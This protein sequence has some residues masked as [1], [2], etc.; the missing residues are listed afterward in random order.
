MVSTTKGFTYKIPI[1]PTTSTP[2]KKPSVGK[3]LCL[4]Y[5][6]L[7]AQKKNVPVELELLN[8]SARKLDVELHHTN[9]NKNEKGIQK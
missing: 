4:L 6:I 7:Y 3:S 5:N 9:W 1:S 8:I 2:V